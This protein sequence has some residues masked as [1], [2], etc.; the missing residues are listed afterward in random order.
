MKYIRTYETFEDLRKPELND[1]VVLHSGHLGKVIEVLGREWVRTDKRKYY[2]IQFV[3]HPNKTYE[4]FGEMAVA[5]FSP[6]EEDCRIYMSAN[7]YN[8]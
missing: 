8:L 2:K 3:D 6:N 1:Y 5:F 4:M 7:K